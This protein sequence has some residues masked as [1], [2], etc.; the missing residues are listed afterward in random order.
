LAPGC[1]RVPGFALPPTMLFSS[2][3]F[4]FLFL[5]TVLAGYALIARFRPGRLQVLWLTAA[6][7]V[8][9]AS[10]A[11]WATAL[12]TVSLCFNYWM[13]GHVAR[14]RSDGHSRAWLWLGLCA[15]LGMLAYFKYANFFIEVAHDTFGMSRA[16]AEIALPLGIS[17]FTFQKIAYLVDAHRERHQE[18]DFLSY[19]LFVMFFP[20]LI[21]GPIVHHRDV[22]PQFARLRDGL[23]SSRF[24]GGFTQFSAGLA[25][26]LLLADTLAPFATQVFSAAESPATIAFADA[27]LAALS[28]TFQIY[29]DFSGYSDMAIGLGKMFGVRLPD[30]FDSPYKSKNITE[31]WRRWHMTL[32]RFLRDYLYIPL[33][34][35]RH[36]L[37]RRYVNLLLTML[38]GGFWHGAGFTFILWGF[39]HGLYLCI[40]H[41]FQQFTRDWEGSKRQLYHPV[42]VLVTF[43]AV[44]VAWVPFR[45]HTLTGTGRIFSSMVGVHGFE[46]AG[47]TNKAQLLPWLCLSAAIAW[48]APN[49]QQI[50]ASQPVQTTEEGGAPDAEAGFAPR[51]PLLWAI[52]VFATILVSL[53]QLSKP[54]EFIYYQF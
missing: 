12:L 46:F 7:F 27:W 2:Y 8:Y 23:T 41:A 43:L 28:Y 34:G 53:A 24:A 9:Y 38:L 22:M 17:F 35:N 37:V 40:H 3:T 49:T 15:N 26:K 25:K 18:R 31:F 6:S 19:T 4:L 33:G 39:L 48:F 5:P 47:L 1:P 21:A 20:Q 30:N 42:A 50:L 44:V 11:L 14:A 10:W 29:F 52:M 51:K 16:T 54:S 36:G 45:A 13:A 32:S